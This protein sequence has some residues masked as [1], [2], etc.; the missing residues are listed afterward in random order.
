VLGQQDTSWNNMK[1]FLGAKAVKDEVS[2][3]SSM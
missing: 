1:K 3:Y 2:V